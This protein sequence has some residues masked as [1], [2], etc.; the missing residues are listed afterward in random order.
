MGYQA[1]TGLYCAAADDSSN[2]HQTRMEKED[3]RYQAPERLPKKRKQAAQYLN[4]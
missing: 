1:T 2:T 3:T 4:K